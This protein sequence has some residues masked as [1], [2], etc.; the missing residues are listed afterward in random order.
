MERSVTEDELTEIAEN[1]KNASVQ[2][3]IS[4]D[5]SLEIVDIGPCK[6]SFEDGMLKL[7]CE[8]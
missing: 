6:L 7:K 3:S 8:I 2:A 1:L 5:Q 4:F